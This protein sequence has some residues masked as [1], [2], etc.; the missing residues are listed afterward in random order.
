MYRPLLNGKRTNVLK[1][2]RKTPWK[3]V[4]LAIGFIFCVSFYILYKT[5]VASS[6]NCLITSRHITFNRNIRP[7]YSTHILSKAN[8]VFTFFF[9]IFIFFLQSTNNWPFQNYCH[10]E[11]LHSKLAE[12]DQTCGHS[13][14]KHVMR[15]PQS[16]HQSDQQRHE[17][18]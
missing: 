12:H 13:H 17:P 8:F 4:S 2:L 1:S 9:S 14:F 16:S 7:N 10:R 15:A 5:F 18:N 6:S 3:W 11:Q